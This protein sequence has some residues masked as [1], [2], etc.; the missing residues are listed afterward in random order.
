MAQ[1]QLASK[2]SMANGM[3]LGLSKDEVHQIQQYERIVHFR[4][5][6]L[7]GS[8]PKIKVP[9]LS[10]TQASATA[11]AP[12]SNASVPG[13][14]TTGSTVQG[15][16]AGNIQSIAS[17]TQQHA[18]L[19]GLGNPPPANANLPARP[20]VS[21]GN[22][23]INPIFLQKSDDL[24]KAEIQ[25]QRQRLERALRD[26]VD[27]RR[28]SMKAS[29]QSEPLADFDL[30]DVLSKALTLVQAAPSSSANPLAAANTSAASDS[31]DENSYYSSQHNSPDSSLHSSRAG[32]DAD[33][34]AQA[35]K[36]SAADR[37]LEGN[38]QVQANQGAQ[39]GLPSSLSHASAT[40]QPQGQALNS[41]PSQTRPISGRVDAAHGYSRYP[42]VGTT[43]R[44]EGG[45]NT[46]ASTSGGGSGNTSRSDESGVMDL[47]D[48]ADRSV[49]AAG[50]Q[51]LGGSMLARQPSPLIQ[52][53]APNIS[54]LAP[55]PSHVSLLATARAR[56][57]A[58]DA[59]DINI[60]QGTTAQ[61]AQLRNEPNVIS[62]PD[63]SPQ[64]GRNGERRK[65]KKKKNNANNNAGN[66]RS[67]RQAPDEPYIKPEPR[68]PSPMSAPSFVRPQKRLRRQDDEDPHY[69]LPD[70]QFSRSY[71]SE[72]AA[73]AYEPQEYRPRPV[74]QA[75]TSGDY[76]YGREY[77]EEPRVPNGA[78]YVRRVQSPGVYAV[79][80]APSEIYATS[81]AASVDRYGREPTRYYRD[82]YEVM[83]MSARPMADRARSRSPVMRERA[84]P[85][86]GPPK[87]PPARVVVD[88]A[89]GR[90]YYEPVSVVRQSVAQQPLRSGEP[91]M[92]YERAPIRAES[93][94]PGP[95]PRDDDVLYQ[96][97]SPIYAA[98]R[99]VV[100][101]PEYAI[102]DAHRVYRHREYSARSMAPPGEE[103]IPARG[104]LEQRRII[105]E[106]PRE[107]MMR[108]TTARPAETVRYE[109]PR[110]YGRVQ[111]VRPE[112]LPIQDYAS[113][114]M[115]PEARL[116]VIQPGP[117]SYSVR[118]SEPQVIRQE[119]SVRPME[120]QQY[121]GQPLPARPEPEVSYI[122]R[123]RV[124]AQEV[125]YADEAPRPM[126]H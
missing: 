18:S 68:S 43:Q 10:A 90:Q 32:N 5:A 111:S 70:R 85:L 44:T 115:H 42:S 64:G 14:G 19:P 2:P 98:P 83:R 61:V 34:G 45:D 59:Q 47:D 26:E 101:Q 95:D 108:A 33:A 93:R 91:E 121:Y 51:Q 126:Y 87:A 38:T 29:A 3:S 102:S 49:P 6:I 55:Q 124:A 50:Q 46:G 117:R 96:R 35:C 22:T 1:G 28:A 23:E 74:S 31:F 119:Y 12:P 52:V 17:N 125:Y 15:H 58:F 77:M 60:P 25:L 9:K 81:P 57:P 120:Q 7:A 56:G 122:E 88:P 78:E 66:K 112:Q 48:S 104:G 79:H 109:L 71:R 107:Y 21:A 30:S 39:V 92:I 54:P 37:P 100:T 86:M 84:S 114:P 99:R 8:H 72:G 13:K 67:V 73:P 80:S 20:F 118:P 4:D 116:E 106:P 11:V 89:T 105:E 63:S 36:L 76:G 40:H 65:G 110:E 27:Q 123:P 94:R 75:V 24:I 103:Y 82:G 41:T 69:A 62:S 97:T 113:V 53:R 16:Q